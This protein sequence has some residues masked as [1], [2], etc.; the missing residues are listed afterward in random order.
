MV[1]NSPPVALI[2]GE[3]LL[4]DLQIMILFVLEGGL[5]AKIT[6]SKPE[7]LFAPRHFLCS[8]KECAEEKLCVPRRKNPWRISRK[9]LASLQQSG[10]IVHRN[11]SGNKNVRQ[12]GL[13]KITVWFGNRVAGQGPNSNLPIVGTHS[14]RPDARCQGAEHLTAQG[15]VVLQ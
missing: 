13:C 2:Q 1:R 3:R 4:G 9:F 10:S 14:P 8:G 15:K 12:V 11:N 6:D 5:S 7:I